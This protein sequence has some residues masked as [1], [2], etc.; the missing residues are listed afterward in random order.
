MIENVSFF[1]IFWIYSLN[2]QEAS[3]YGLQKE[4]RKKGV[5]FFL[6]FINHP[7]FFS[8]TN[9]LILRQQ[10]KQLPL[11]MLIQCMGNPKIMKLYIHQFLFTL[12]SL[13]P[14]FIN[15]HHSLVS[16]CCSNI[17]ENFD[18]SMNHWKFEL[19]YCILMTLMYHSI[20]T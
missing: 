1:N 11:D 18:V 14:L 8:C 16:T 3:Q 2:P 7:T 12:L 15:L 5:Y 6:T 4:K 9:V 10:K 20:A 17:K 19:Y 13:S